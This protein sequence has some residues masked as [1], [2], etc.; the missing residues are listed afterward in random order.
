[1]RRAQAPFCLGTTHR[2]QPCRPP[3]TGLHV[4]TAPAYYSGCSVWPK[5]RGL[6]RPLTTRTHALSQRAAGAMYAYIFGHLSLQ[7][8]DVLGESQLTGYAQ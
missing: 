2:G 1:M 8:I 4:R 7:G 6:H 3:S 5:W